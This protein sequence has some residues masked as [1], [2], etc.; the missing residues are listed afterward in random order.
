MYGDTGGMNLYIRRIGHIG[1]LTITLDS[2]GTVTAHRIGTQEVSI[3]ITACGNHHGI[4]REALQLTSN[5]IL[6]N[7]TTGTAVH[8][9][10]VLHLITGEE[11]HLASMNLT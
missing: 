8:N 2:S 10:H 11:L 4:G 7:D 3:T 6:G 1:S 5:Q 9:H